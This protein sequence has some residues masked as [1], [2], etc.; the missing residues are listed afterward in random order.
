VIVV[1]LERLGYVQRKPDSLNYRLGLKA[2]GLGRGMMK[3]LSIAEAALPHLRVLVDQVHLPAHLAIPDGDQGV[4]IQKVDT[5]GPDQNRHVCR[6]P[7]GSALHGGRQGD[8][9]IWRRGKRWSAHWRSKSTS[10]TLANTITS[11]RALRRELAR[12]RELGYAVDDEEEELAVR[13]V[14]VPVFHPNGR[15]AAAL[16]VVGTTEQ[17][18][19]DGIKPLAQRLKRTA[20]GIFP[21]VP[22]EQH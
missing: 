7:D 19:L 2:Y 18:P 12:V 20:A 13:C 10:G 21:V 9:G 4:Y 1:T 14:A 16:S 15:F 6:P 11:S 5:P 17:I 22:I 8:S 3:N